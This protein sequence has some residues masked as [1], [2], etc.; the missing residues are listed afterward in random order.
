MAI[1]TLQ[2]RVSVSVWLPCAAHAELARVASG[3]G[4]SSAVVA[5]R[6]VA[7]AVAS[8]DGR[9]SMPAPT[10]EAVEELRTAGHEVN[11]L[12]P[13][14]GAATTGL[15]EAAI[16]TRL[17][18]AVERVA[19]ASDGVRLPPPRASATPTLL[20]DRGDTAG[21]VGRDRWRLVRVTTDPDT[22]A[23]WTQAAAAAG[24]RSTAN[25]VRD[26]L[27]ATHGLAVARPPAAATIEARAV[28]GRV[29]GLLA[30]TTTALAIRPHLGG[31]LGGPV[32]AAEDA[33]WTAL[34]SLLTHG[35]QP[36]ARR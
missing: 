17:G 28:A 20:E 3:E 7:R 31:V 15:Q 16:A 30:Q 19:G 36:T 4:V 6:A 21:G 2:R 25:W 22:A 32:E 11:R 9:V 23:C 13:A 26:A 29:L 34:H 33:L 35:G 8:M 24:F 27:A 10:V 5:R 18:A 1:A 14:L 12:L